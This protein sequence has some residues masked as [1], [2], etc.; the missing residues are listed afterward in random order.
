MIF[1]TVLFLIT[2][3]INGLYTALF[4]IT[5]RMARSP[6]TT[7]ANLKKIRKPLVSPPH[8]I[9]VKINGRT[10]PSPPT[11]IKEIFEYSP[12]IT[13]LMDSFPISLL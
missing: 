3:Y 4:I 8:M 2:I 6:A 11:P 10:M 5:Y 7:E 12:V 1:L 13:D 9:R